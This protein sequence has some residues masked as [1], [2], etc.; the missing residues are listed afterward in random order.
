MR[1]HSRR[2]ATIPMIRSCRGLVDPG[3]AGVAAP[4]V[5]SG[6]PPPPP[7]GQPSPQ[8]QQRKLRRWLQVVVAPRPPRRPGAA[9]NYPR[10]SPPPLLSLRCGTVCYRRS[11]NRIAGVVV[12]RRR[13]LCCCAAAA[14]RPATGEGVAA[15]SAVP[16]PG[17]AR[18]RLSGPEGET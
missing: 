1:P 5:A 6:H 14:S 10:P 18:P 4:A 13:L 8:L 2:L 17:P 16:E 3:D 9:A 7:P 15:G 11:D 12:R